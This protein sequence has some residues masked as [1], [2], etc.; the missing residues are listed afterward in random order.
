MDV[1]TEILD[2]LGSEMTVATLRSE[3]GGKSRDEITKILNRWFPSDDNE[4]LAGKI[5]DYLSRSQAAAALGSIRSKRKSESSAA[6]GAAPV[7]PGSRPRGW[8]KG[9]KRKSQS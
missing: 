4:K 1:Q 7:R 8:P 9:K 2:Y 5:F 3:F 6:N